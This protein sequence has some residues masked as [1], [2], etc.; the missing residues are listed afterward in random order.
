MRVHNDEWNGSRNHVC[1]AV[2]PK[3]EVRCNPSTTRGGIADR[4]HS[5]P[6]RWL[7]SSEIV[8]K[9][10]LLTMMFQI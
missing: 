5:R 9:V 2:Q 4:D 10:V 7:L 1:N 3:T 6:T 8:F